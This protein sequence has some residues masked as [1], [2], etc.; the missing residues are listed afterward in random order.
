MADEATTETPKSGIV[1]FTDA[2]GNTRW[3]DVNSKL[4]ERHVRD[5][6]KDDDKHEAVAPDAAPVDPPAE[7]K[8]DKIPDVVVPPEDKSRRP[9]VAGA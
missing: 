2:D 4:Y 6:S 3:G 1:K 5:T 9:R 8:A 7:V